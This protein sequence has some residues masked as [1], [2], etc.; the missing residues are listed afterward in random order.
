MSILPERIGL[1]IAFRSVTSRFQE[2]Y[3]L[4]LLDSNKVVFII[5]KSILR[6][7]VK[8]LFYIFVLY[9]LNGDVTNWSVS[10]RHLNYNYFPRIIIIIII[11][12]LELVTS[13]LADGFSLESAWQ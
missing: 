1:S 6:N 2:F 9:N 3:N 11:H 7:C 10:W 8:Y 5:S 12:S 4:F 13:A